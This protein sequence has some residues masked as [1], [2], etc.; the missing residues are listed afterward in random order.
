MI[1]NTVMVNVPRVY[2]C[3]VQ[4]YAILY[5]PAVQSVRCTVWHTTGSGREEETAN[6]VT[7]YT[8]WIEQ[9]NG[10]ASAYS[11]D[12]NTYSVKLG[13]GPL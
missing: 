5:Q 2:A 11:V 1:Q 10:H 3:T 6:G 13:K 12:N 4:L 8:N 7:A 9:I